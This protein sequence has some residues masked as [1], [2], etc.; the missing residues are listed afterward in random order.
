MPALWLIT[1]GHKRSEE[2]LLLQA[3]GFLQMLARLRI[4]NIDNIDNIANINNIASIGNIDSIDNID[5]MDTEANID[6]TNLSTARLQLA[7][8]RFT[9]SLHSTTLPQESDQILD[10][11]PQMHWKAA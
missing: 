10:L 4:D 3:D 1:S 2:H 7:T 5:N 11:S 6:I 9:V 8:T